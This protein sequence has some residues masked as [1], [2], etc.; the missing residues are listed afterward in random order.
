M[1]LLRLSTAAELILLLTD[2]CVYQDFFF[3][4]YWSSPSPLSLI[5]K[6]IYEINLK[7]MPKGFRYLGCCFFLYWEKQ[8]LWHQ[9]LQWKAQTPRL[10]SSRAICLLGLL[11][12][13]KYADLTQAWCWCH[14]GK[15]FSSSMTPSRE[16]L[17]AK[18]EVYYLSW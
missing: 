8:A 3:F 11:A 9:L 14:R 5:Y 18:L 7:G 17:S 13:W 1:L 10:V 2:L 15:Y 6:C 12:T 16:L 4:K